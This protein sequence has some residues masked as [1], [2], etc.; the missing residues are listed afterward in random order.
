M[1]VPSSRASCFCR[2]S[3]LSLVETGHPPEDVHAIRRRVQHVG[4]RAAGR[5]VRDR[6]QHVLTVL[7]G[8][9]EHVPDA[10]MASRV[11]AFA[12]RP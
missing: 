1:S 3:T 7:V 10:P 12:L 2:A 6:G 11:R 5:R 4:R 9:E 8:V